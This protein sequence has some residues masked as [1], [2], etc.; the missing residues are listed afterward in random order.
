[1]SAPRDDVYRLAA[2]LETLEQVLRPL[3]PPR[4]I[5]GEVSPPPPPPLPRQRRR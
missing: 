4:R 2:L 5:D 1:M 3:P